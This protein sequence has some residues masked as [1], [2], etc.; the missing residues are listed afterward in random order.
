MA[1][2]KGGGGKMNFK[3]VYEKKT[4][5]FKVFDHGLQLPED[6]YFFLDSDL[7][8]VLFDRSLVGWPLQLKMFKVTR[9]IFQSV[10]EEFLDQF[11]PDTRVEQVN[12]AGSDFY[13]AQS[14]HAKEFNSSLRRNYVGEHREPV[15][16]KVDNNGKQKF[17]VNVSYVRIEA[18]GRIL[19]LFETIATGKSA[20]ASF[21]RI[22][23]QM[24]ENGL[25][26]V[27]V[28]T[29]AGSIDGAQALYEFLKHFTIKIKLV[30]G[31]GLFPLGDDGTALMWRGK[32]GEEPITL[33]EYIEKG[34]EIFLPGECCIGDWGRRNTD[35]DGYLV[36]W[37][38]EKERLKRK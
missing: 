34:K 25:E 32:N 37:E 14:A 22:L 13:Q 10:R 1:R 31:M 4:L 16:G 36:E 8:D 24:I 9:S 21:G 28:V 5:L 38:E 18:Y 19:F 17:K 29:I 7:E 30:I 35:P 6:T 11:P 15:F 23:P 33:P 2:C 3:K 12:L 20:I 27:V 26:Q